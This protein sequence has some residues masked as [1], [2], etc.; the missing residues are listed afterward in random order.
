MDHHDMQRLGDYLRSERQAKG[1]STRRLAAAIGVD[2]AQIVRLEQGRVQSP[3]ATSLA[4]IAEHLELALADVFGLAGI[5]V[6]SELP[7]FRP[8]LRAKYRE[9]PPDAVA[10]LERRFQEIADKYGTDGPRDGEDEH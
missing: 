6:P 3:H 9:L 4:A 10:E 7:S 2:M 8:Y 1:W 5:A